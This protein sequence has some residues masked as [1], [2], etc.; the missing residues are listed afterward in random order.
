MG[1]PNNQLTMNKVCV[2]ITGTNATGKTTLAKALIEC[3]GGIKE[4]TKELHSVM[5]AVYV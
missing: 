2:F 5:T 1:K 4:A 3:F